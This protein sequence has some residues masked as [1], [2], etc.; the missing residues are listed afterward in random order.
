VLTAH[1]RERLA[2]YK[3]PRHL[4]LRDEPSMP[5][6][7]SGKVDKLRLRADAAALVAAAQSR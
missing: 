4:W 2:S 1:C 6:K 3:V 5:L 7:G